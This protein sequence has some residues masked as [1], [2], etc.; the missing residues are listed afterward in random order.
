[1]SLYFMLV[2]TW[3]AYGTSK[4]G[5]EGR[6]KGSKVR[7]E[8]TKKKGGTHSFRFLK[9]RDR[10]R[11]GKRERESERQ[12]DTGSLRLRDCVGDRLSL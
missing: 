7:R 9:E 11:R 12:R 8:C 5:R 2:R 1:M 6:E 4:G 10:G 3:H